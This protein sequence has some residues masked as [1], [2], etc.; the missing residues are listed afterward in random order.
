MIKNNN[1]FYLLHKYYGNKY[2]NF[3]NFVNDNKINTIS[4]YNLILNKNNQ[5]GGLTYTTQI[6]NAT[7]SIDMYHKK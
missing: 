7:Y 3:Y 4:D 1:I 2:I 5:I 6:K